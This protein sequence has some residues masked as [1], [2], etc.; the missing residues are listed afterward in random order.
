M[1]LRLIEQVISSPLWRKSSGLSYLHRSIGIIIPVTVIILAFAGIFYG[2]ICRYAAYDGGSDCI[3]AFLI[4][5]FLGVPVSACM[6][7]ISIVGFWMLKGGSS[8]L[9][10]A[11]S[12]PF[13]SVGQYSMTVMPLFLI[14][15]SFAALAGFAE[16]GFNLAKRWLEA[17]PGG[18]IHATVIGAT[19][20]GAASGSGAATSLF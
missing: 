5:L 16:E 6:G 2:I 17:I 15:G 4:L 3:I 19:A 12:G 8:A 9:G 20:F 13:T 11:A 7:V 1:S 10:L 14:M 18:I